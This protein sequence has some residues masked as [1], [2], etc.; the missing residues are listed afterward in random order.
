MTLIY[1]EI[2]GSISRIQAPEA[3]EGFLHLPAG[4]MEACV[5]KGYHLYKGDNGE[6]Y[7]GDSM[8]NVAAV[9][10]PLIASYIRMILMK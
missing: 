2:D 8:G 9:T 10:M 1:Q 5:S 4:S 6:Y 7:L 3:D